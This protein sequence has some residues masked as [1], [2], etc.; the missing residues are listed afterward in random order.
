MVFTIV[1][2]NTRQFK[3]QSDNGEVIF[4][5]ARK[6]FLKQAKKL[7]VG[8]KV[9]L[10]EDGCIYQVMPRLHVRSNVFKKTRLF[11]LSFG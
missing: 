11:K 5:T 10:D 9:C 8:D 2:G 1:G 4:S 3:L 7:Y 6:S